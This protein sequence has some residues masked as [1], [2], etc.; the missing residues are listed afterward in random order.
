MN[1]VGSKT[2]W[3]TGVVLVAVLVTVAVLGVRATRGSADTLTATVRRGDVVVALTEAGTLRPAA[4]MTYRSPLAGRETEITYLTPEGTYVHDG[5]LLVRLD[6]TGLAEELER[7]I[8]AAR[9]ADVEVKAAD[10]D[11]VDAAAALESATDGAGAIDAEEAQTRLALARKNVAR[12]QSE[13]DGMQPLL[14]KGFA[15]KDE[16]DKAQFDLEQAQADLTVMTKR[17]ALLTG[18]TR[19]RDEQRA[20][21][22]LDQKDAQVVNAQQHAKDAAAAVDALRAAVADCNI[23]ATHAGLVVY[24][25]LLG[26]TPRRRVRVGDRVSSTQGLVTIPEVER[27]LV[28]TSVREGDLW[29]VH[30]GQAVTVSVDAFPAL[31]LTG[32]VQSIGTVG[33]AAERGF[34]EKRFSVIVALDGANRELRPD[35]TARAAIAVAERRQV[36][37][38]PLAAVTKAGDAWQATLVR[39]WGGLEARTVSVGENDGFQ[40]EILDG[41]KE[42]DRV[43]LTPQK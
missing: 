34:E 22:Q 4:S 43:S 12:L 19:P 6:S 2:R 33:N 8:A 7:A 23:Y 39:A 30:T 35:M 38:L 11:R 14:A 27:M 40:L 32:H 36:L 42:G 41:L 16:L 37:T 26:S 5:D 20:R 21:V 31:H 1:S 15:T 13:Y 28:D 24:E 9:Q 18:K 17:V 10:A 3:A 29:R 25:E